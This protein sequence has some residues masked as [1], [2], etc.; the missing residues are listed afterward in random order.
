MTLKKISPIVFFI[1]A[2]G[3]I[4]TYI[5]PTKSMIGTDYNNQ[6]L[7]LEGIVLY[8]LPAFT[9]GVYSIYYWKYRDGLD[10]LI[11]LHLLSAIAFVLVSVFWIPK[12]PPF[13]RRYLEFDEI[14]L[15]RPPLQIAVGMLLITIL[16]F[17]INVYMKSSLRDVNRVSGCA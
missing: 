8:I 13:P 9:F 10:T 6:Y 11:G 16:I 17:A 5:L 3:Y 14:S 15:F 1:M 12:I 4:A 7:K 2:I